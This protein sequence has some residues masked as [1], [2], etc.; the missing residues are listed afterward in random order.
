MQ[1]R[2]D[3]VATAAYQPEPAAAAAARRFV[4]DTL[5]T[6]QVVGR[7]A[8]QDE[9]VDDAVLL[10]SELVTNAV[11]H[12]GTPV[13]VTC[14]LA[15]G[16]VEVVV[17]D[18]HP[19][20]LVP[21][22]EPRDSSGAERTSG[23]GLMLPS[24]L[25]SSWGV[26]YARTAKAVWFRLGIADFD[27]ADEAGGT[28]GTGRAAGAVPRSA[29][30]GMLTAAGTVGEGQ[31]GPDGG[32]ARDRPA[33]S[34]QLADGEWPAG[35]ERPGDGRPPADG[36]PSGEHGPPGN[37][38][39]SG[40]DGQPGNDGQSAGVAKPAGAASEWPPAGLPVWARRNLGRLGYEEL[41]SH[42]VEAARA[43]MAADA[44]YLLAAGE[45]GE[46]RVRAAAGAGQRSGPGFAQLAAGPVTVAAGP[47]RALADAALSLVTVPLMAEGRVTGVLA[48]AAAE[49]GRFRERDAARLQEL[50]DRSTPTLERARLGEMERARRARVSYLEE[51]GQV[52]AGSFDPEKIVA[53]AAQLVVPQLADWCAVLLADA[54]GV[55]RPVYLSHVDETRAAALS[56]LFEHALPAALPAGPPDGAA[57]GPGRL[58]MAGQRWP[59]MPVPPARSGTAGGA[60]ATARTQPGAPPG[61]AQLAA[62]GAWCFPL[63]APDDRRG[64]LVIGT[65]AGG[66]LSAEVTELAEGLARRL[67]LAL[68]NASRQARQQFTSRIRQA[69]PPPPD[70]PRIPG[71]ELAVTHAEPGGG[72][73]PGGDFY[74]IFPVGGDHWRFVIADVCG[75]GPEAAAIGGL[76]RHTLR[77]LAREGHGIGAVLER[78]NALIIDEGEQ[79]R[80]LTLVHGEITAGLARVSLACAGHPLPL[81]LRSTAAMPEPAADPQPLL[82]VIEGLTFSTQTLDLDHGDLLLAMTDGITHRRH[83]YRQLDDGDGVAVLLAESRDLSAGAVAARIQQ[84]AR[85]FGPA[86]LADDMA[87]LVLRAS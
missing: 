56:W 42:T 15:H 3:L 51:A 12:A 46:L 1:A 13:Q 48:V 77:I 21:D 74:D 85:D 35:S 38:R 52:L 87:L 23:R 28:D 44:A 40:S 49:P 33:G 59:A 84:A 66:R 68:D 45:D 73:S 64:L 47:A 63:T 65:V 70:P 80:F 4:R 54:G 27:T 86:P 6:W 61:A 41:L 10:T 67:A 32:P 76:A 83:G 20:Q 81:V 37:D 22:R 36:G 50:A 78:L 57:S 8:S 19:V 16:A 71:V 7:S 79:A 9:L 75:T 34:A 29:A 58:R 17:L 69:V 60:T 72:S 2:D 30:S 25:A 11:V 62:D 43:M 26:T 55:P 24:E 31:P 39:Q 14:R 18:R 5:R 53:L 82:G